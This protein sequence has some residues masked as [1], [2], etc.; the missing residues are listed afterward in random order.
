[1]NSDPT[2]EQMIA[3]LIQSCT[4]LLGLAVPVP[5]Q[6]L[7]DA[8]SAEMSMQA[9]YERV[10][11]DVTDAEV[12]KKYP[13]WGFFIRRESTRQEIARVL[14]PKQLNPQDP[15]YQA[16]LAAW[17]NTFMLV[18]TPPARGAWRALGFTVEF[19]QTPAPSP[20]IAP[21]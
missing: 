19:F 10:I 5:P 14:V 13:L 4:E 11:A 8:I 15:Q 7:A 1:V 3:Q 2:H 12:R 6:Q 21:H 16:Q 9:Q 20:I 17:T 18:T